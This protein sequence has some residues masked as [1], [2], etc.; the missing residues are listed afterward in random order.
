[1]EALIRNAATRLGLEEY[2]VKQALGALFRFLIQKQRR[3]EIGTVINVEAILSLLLLGPSQES[4][5]TTTTTAVE[6]WIHQSQQPPHSDENSSDASHEHQAPPG[7]GKRP[8]SSTQRPLSSPSTLV[9]LLLLLL[10]VLGIWNVLKQVL[11]NMYPP[12]L[13]LM[14]S[15]QDG[16]WLDQMLQTCGISH[17]QGIV[18]VGMLVDLMKQKLQPETVQDLLQHVPA[19]Y[20]FV[21]EQRRQEQ[22]QQT[23]PSSSSSSSSSSNQGH[24]NENSKFKRE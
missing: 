1:M 6:D 19:L 3:G 13:V 9:G 24:R 20:A 17:E 8:P 15:L 18:V 10:Q 12:A 2:R 7:R 11:H 23:R 4:T 14:E 22:Q 21:Q 16:V 5:T